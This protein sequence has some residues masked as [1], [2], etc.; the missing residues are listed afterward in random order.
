MGGLRVA[1]LNGGGQKT[2][3]RGSRLDASRYDVHDDDAFP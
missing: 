1:E 3:S 2:C